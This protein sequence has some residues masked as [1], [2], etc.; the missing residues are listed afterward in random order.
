M[1]WAEMNA[2]TAVLRTHE[3]NRPDDNF[4]IYT[5]IETIIHFSKMTKIY[6][7]LGFYRKMLIQRHSSKFVSLRM[8]DFKNVLKIKYMDL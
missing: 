7:S 5:D 6:R 3:G 4:Q 2:F 1:R 8:I